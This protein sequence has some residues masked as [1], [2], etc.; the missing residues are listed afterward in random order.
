M[1]LYEYQC[2]EGHNR[3]M[4]RSM[5]DR[6]DPCWCMNPR[7]RTYKDMCFDTLIQ[8]I[9]LSGLCGKPMRRIMSL[10]AK[11]GRAYEGG[12]QINPL[13]LP[14][15]FNPDG[16]M[17]LRNIKVGSRREFKST[18]KSFGLRELETTGDHLIQGGTAKRDRERAETDRLDAEA[19]SMAQDHARFKR[20]PDQVKK[21][22]DKAR[23]NGAI[24]AASEL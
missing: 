23:A 22:L 10:P 5:A 13:T 1:F 2:E 3:T 24:I 21:V 8:K 12:L 11:R 16:S 7:Q 18:L 6:D 4:R 20:N 14:P 9:T 19:T 15:A 17:S